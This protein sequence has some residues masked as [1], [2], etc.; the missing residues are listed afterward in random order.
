MQQTLLTQW[1]ETMRSLGSGQG[2]TM[3]NETIQAWERSVQ[4]SLD[5]QTTWVR[6][7][8]ESLANANGIPQEMRDQVRAGQE[9]LQQWTDAQRQLW[10]NWF[11]V[12]QNL[13]PSLEPGT[14]AQAGQ[15][16][17]QLWQ[18]TMSRLVETQTEWARRWTTGGLG[19]SPQR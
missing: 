2:T 7:W 12:I 9:A 10:Q 19:S 14:G 17:A 8:T 13:N 4:Q 11:G 16:I 15:N 5:A 1:I 3:W 18:E 6:S